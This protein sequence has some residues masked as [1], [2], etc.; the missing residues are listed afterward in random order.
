MGIERQSEALQSFLRTQ[1]ID[2]N[3]FD[4]ELTRLLAL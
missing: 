4:S 1:H 2:Q 3:A